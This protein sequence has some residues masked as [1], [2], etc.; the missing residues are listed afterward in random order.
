M[1]P[2]LGLYPKEGTIYSGAAQEMG[3]SGVC[4]EINNTT[5]CKL[6]LTANFLTCCFKFQTPGLARQNYQVF[7]A[8]FFLIGRTNNFA[9]ECLASLFLI[10]NLSCQTRSLKRETTG[11]NVNG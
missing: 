5:I 4:L 2:G 3:E 11:K 1:G 9:P 7:L 8:I 6:G 10:C